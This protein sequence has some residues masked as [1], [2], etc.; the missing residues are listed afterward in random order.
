MSEVSPIPLPYFNMCGFSVIKL[1]NPNPLVSI[2]TEPNL[3]RY[4]LGGYK[5]S[6][7]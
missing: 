3:V 7:F 1:K 5:L 4:I 2:S 6:P